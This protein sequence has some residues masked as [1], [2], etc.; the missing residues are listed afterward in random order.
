MEE[1]EKGQGVGEKGGEKMK[2]SSRPKRKAIRMHT[3]EAKEGR[4]KKEGFR[5]YEEWINIT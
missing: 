4:K 5:E 1:K 3:S 2:S